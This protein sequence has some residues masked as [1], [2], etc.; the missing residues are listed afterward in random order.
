[1][2]AYSRDGLAEIAFASQKNSIS[3]YVLRKQVVEANAALL[4][5]LSVGKGC[6]RFTRPEQVGPAIIRPL[7]AGSAADTG[8]VC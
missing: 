5:G 1:M 2:P 3:F 8:P 4:A 6:I 7:L